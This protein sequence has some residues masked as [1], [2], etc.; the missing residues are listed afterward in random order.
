MY[1]SKKYT[2][3]C[4][5]DECTLRL[6]SEIKRGKNVISNIRISVI[7]YHKRKQLSHPSYLILKNIGR[8]RVYLLSAPVQIECVW[9][10][11]MLIACL[12]K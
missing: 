12:V 6:S 2:A 1:Q 11:S 10:M 5:R 8:Y 3:A 4:M 9:D 7:K